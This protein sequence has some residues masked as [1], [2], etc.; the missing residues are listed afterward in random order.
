MGAIGSATHPLQWLWERKAGI[1]NNRLC[2]AHVALIDICTRGVL[3]QFA[4]VLRL[5]HCLAV[6]NAIPLGYPLLSS[7]HSSRVPTPLGCSLFDLSEWQM[8][9]RRHGEGWVVWMQA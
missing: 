2:T 6:A 8:Q 4:P 7:T 9:M 1:G 3:L 5:K